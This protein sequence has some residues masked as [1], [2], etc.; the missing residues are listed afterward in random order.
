MFK[1]RRTL[2][3]A[4]LIPALLFPAAV[5][6]QEIDE[7]ALEVA[8]RSDESDNGFVNSIAHLKMVLRN[9]QGQE[10][11]RSMEIRT[12]EREDAG[13]GDKSILLLSAPGDVKGTAFLSYA[14]LIEPDDQWIFLPALKRVKRIASVNKS[15]PFLGSEFAYED[16]TS[17][18]VGKYLYR[19]LEEEPCG[20]FTCDVIERTPLYE[21]SGYSKQIVWI[22]QTHAQFRKIAFYDRAGA[23]VKTLMLEDYRLYKERFWRAH[24]LEM[25]NLRNGKSTTL[26][27]ESFT[28]D[29]AL[30]K[31]GFTKGALPRLR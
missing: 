31:R 7:R 24:R 3:I 2:C 10:T 25:A 9:A 23:H 26:L 6:G 16:F 17:Q 15:G 1:G 28:F 12:L 13:V 22:D 11:L 8:T 21:Y 18:E 14:K 27:F 29:K 20:D 19:Y 5:W 30:N 4:T